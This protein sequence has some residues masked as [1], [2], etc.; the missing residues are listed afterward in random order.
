MFV[1]LPSPKATFDTPPTFRRSRHFV[2]PHCKSRHWG[3]VTKCRATLKKA[4]LSWATFSW[5][6]FSW[7]TFSRATFSRATF[8]RGAVGF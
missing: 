5:A 8:D 2:A 3:R 7:A 4:T 6:T 1:E